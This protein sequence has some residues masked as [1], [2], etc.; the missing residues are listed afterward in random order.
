MNHLYSMTEAHQAEKDELT[1][2]ITIIYEVEK[3]ATA[4]S[5]LK[6]KKIA[7][8]KQR[9]KNMEALRAI[10]DTKQSD[11]IDNDTMWIDCC[12]TMVKMQIDTAEKF[13]QQQQIRIEKDITTA[14]A[15]LKRLV[16]DLQLLAP[17]KGIDP[18]S[19]N[20]LLKD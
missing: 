16:K 1:Q 12:G 11:D 10:R 17:S 14:T 2:H 8:D 6:S 20:L 3:I 18:A 13:L 7:L 5:K 15:D 4:I 19:L 9:Q